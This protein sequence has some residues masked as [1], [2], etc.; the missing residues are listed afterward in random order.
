M[1]HP[2]IPLNLLDF[3]EFSVSVPFHSTRLS[4]TYMRV[5]IRARSSICRLLSQAPNA[6]EHLHNL[7]VPTIEPSILISQCGKSADSMFDELPK[8]DVVSATA[9][10]SRFTRLNH[11]KKAIT[12][13]SRMFEYDVRPNEFTL[14]TVT[15]S[16]VV[17]KDLNSGKQFHVIS[18]NLA[19]SQMFT[20]VVHFWIFM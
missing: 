18:I 12:I 19:F 14:G 20:W 4:F 17:L 10:V 8:C 16:S 13:F 5:C 6:R 9:L 15:H 11:H 7:G 1:T 3:Y 2:I